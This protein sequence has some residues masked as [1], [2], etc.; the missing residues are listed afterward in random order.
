MTVALH[1]L[2]GQ[3]LIRSTRGRIQVRDRGGMEKMCGSFYGVPESEYERL[4]GTKG[5]KDLQQG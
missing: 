1:M 2:E 4:R 3:G 5:G